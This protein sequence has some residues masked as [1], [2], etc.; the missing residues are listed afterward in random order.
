MIGLLSPIIPLNTM[1]ALLELLPLIGLGGG[2]LMGKSINPDIAMY[3][4]SYGAIIGTVL[5]FAIYRAM[6]QK[7]QKMTAIT[8]WLLIIF[9]TLTIVLHNDLF[10]K[11]KPTVLS[12]AFA[13]AFLASAF[14]TKQTLLELMMGGQFDMPAPNWLKLNWAWV[15]FNFLVGLANLVIVWQITQ[16][17]LSDDSWVTFKFSLL[18]IS[19]VFIGGQTVYLLKN[20]KVKTETSGGGE[21]NSEREM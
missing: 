12:W 4:L 19:L 20:G 1:H 14:W 16:G 6:R 17:V 11:L 10:V 3:Y 9:A 13:V 21:S 18:P 2:Y 8:G 5:Q 15:I 7:M